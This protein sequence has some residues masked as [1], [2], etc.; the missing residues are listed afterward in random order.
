[1][2]LP[3]NIQLHKNVT[4]PAQLLRRQL[5]VANQDHAQHHTFRRTGSIRRAGGFNPYLFCARSP[6]AFTV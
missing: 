1:M 5:A 4:L 3:E 2:R 6:P